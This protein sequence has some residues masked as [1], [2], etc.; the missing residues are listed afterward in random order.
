[1]SLIPAG[2][3]LMG[4]P[5]TEKDR[6][7]YELLHKVRLTKPFYLATTEVTQQQWISIMGITP[8]IRNATER[9]SHPATYVSWNDAQ[10]FITKL[11]KKEGVFYRLPSEAEWE[12][13]CR[14]GITSPFHFG[15]TSNGSKSNV[16][17]NYP[18]GTTTKGKCLR[19]TSRVGS[20]D[21]N[22]FGLYDMHGNVWEWC[23]D[24]YDAEYYKLF[25]NK[26]AADPSGPKS[27]PTLGF[28]VLRGGSWLSVARY[29]RSADRSWNAPTFQSYNTGFRLSRTP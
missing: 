27:E 19:T 5:K 1:M 11:N 8:W 29:T 4:S 17:G 22:S 6:S 3:F 24:W 25:V 15:S 7:N 9:D 13:A 26:I 20:Y 12:Y 23:S 14:A 10:D 28:R 16:N 2:E 18:Y 21:S